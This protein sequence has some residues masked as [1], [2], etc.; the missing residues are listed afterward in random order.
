MR[1]PVRRRSVR[2]VDEP[3]RMAK[4]HIDDVPWVRYVSPNGKFRGAYKELS[5]A[6]GAVA[7]APV[8][9]GGH[10]FDLALETLAPGECF[11][12]FHEHGA[13]WEMYYILSGI[14]TVRAGDERYDVRSGDVIL[15]RPGEAHQ[16]T[17]TGSEDLR[18]LI[19]ADNPPLDVCRYPDSGKVGIFGPYRRIVRAVDVDYFDGEE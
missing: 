17:N 5:V 19:I 18:Y 8:G 12:P 2:R 13:Q 3:Q 10:P 15:R 16:M 1:S 11:C 4:V 6:L 7:D 9:A 14:A